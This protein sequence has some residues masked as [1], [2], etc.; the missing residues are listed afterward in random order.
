[1]PAPGGTYQFTTGTSVAAALVSGI[2]ALLI[3]LNPRLKPP[4]IK[5]V[6]LATATDLGPKGRDNQFG[7]VTHLEAD[8]SE[9]AGE[10][11]VDPFCGTGTT[12]VAA[13]RMGRRWIGIDRVKKYAEMARQR[14]AHTAV[15]GGPML[16]VSTPKQQSRNALEAT[17][18]SLTI[19]VATP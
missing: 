18:K 6:L 2:A 8:A 14:V 3:E 7:A 1:M 13:K 10:I 4:E 9:F 5:N 12:C 16:L 17:W 19:A 11:V 15:D